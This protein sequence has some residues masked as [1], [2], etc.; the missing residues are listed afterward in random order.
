MMRSHNLPNHNYQTES[1]G[2]SQGLRMTTTRRRCHVVFRLLRVSALAIAIIPMLAL[3][4]TADSS[5]AYPGLSPKPS[6]ASKITS[7][8]KSGFGKVTKALIPSPSTKRDP[9]PISLEVP[10]KPSAGFYVAVAHMAEQKGDVAQAESD[11]RKALELEPNHV[12][13]LM[14]YAHMLDRQRKLTQ[15]AELY[16]MVVRTHPGN[17]T[18]HNDLAICCARQGKLE[19]AIRSLKQAVQLRPGHALFRNN[20][21]TILVQTKQLDEAFV[22][23]SAVHPKPVAYYNLGFLLHQAGDNRGATR[24]FREALSLDPSLVQARIWVNKLQADGVVVESTR[25]QA[26]E[27]ARQPQSVARR[28]VEPSVAVPPSAAAAPMPSSGT[29]ASVPQ[30]TPT[31]QRAPV[32]PISAPAQTPPAHLAPLPSLKPLPPIHGNY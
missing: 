23:L 6:T 13:A 10:A 27:P 16:H 15:A 9:D 2:P 5:S 12:D 11:Y 29:T 17:A 3:V 18:A 14:G 26:V 19:E 32:P 20:I 30:M 24:L 22:H 1:T 21:A 4:A 8:V 7:S 25:P 31:R 28:T